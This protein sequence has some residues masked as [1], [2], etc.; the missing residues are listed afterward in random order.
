MNSY[1]EFRGSTM[2]IKNIKN[3]KKQ[4]G[5]AT[6]IVAVVI[7]VVITIMVLFAARVGVFDQRMS[8]NEARY[9][10]AFAIAEAGLDYTAERFESE[11]TRLY[12]GST[13]GSSTTTLAAIL[14]NSQFAS[15]TEIDGTT[16]EANEPYFTAAITDSGISPS[17]S[18]INAYTVIATGVGSDGTATATIQRQFSMAYVFGGSVP[19]VPIIVGGAVGTG[20]NF[21]IVAN[22]NGGGEGVPVSIWTGPSGANVTATSSSATCHFEFY[23]GNN[24]QCSNPSGND[25]NIS[26]GTNPATPIPSYDPDYPDILPNDPDFPSDLFEFIF[27]VPRDSW[28]TIETQTN[29]ESNNTQVTTD[30]TAM[31][32]AGTAAGQNFP[33]WWI[34]GNCSISGGP[35]IGTT[36]NPVILVVADGQLKVTGGAQI[37]GVVF[38]F[39]KPGGGS[40]SADLGGTTEIVGSFIS[41]VGG[42]AMQGS[43][44]VVY[45]L[46]VIDSFISNGNNYSFAWIPGTWRDF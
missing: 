32:A 35:I 1:S 22:P 2:T 40:P 36:D 26:R 29:V 14:A 37:N 15:P 21:N 25:E 13:P 6:I 34:N 11:F 7:L 45:D 44:L 33:I 23:T 42:S 27:G 12:D 19:D 8:A 18:A 30:C 41:D 46:S 3:I 4:K 16:P 10:E 24:A 43:Y 20:G 28:T 31:V 38:L 39:D 9:K 17:G 5:M